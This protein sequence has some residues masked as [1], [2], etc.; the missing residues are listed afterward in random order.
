MP[1][2]AHDAFA[3]LVAVAAAAVEPLALDRPAVAGRPGQVSVWV[4]GVPGTSY[5]RCSGQDYRSRCLS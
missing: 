3:A 5:E 1:A 4:R 2:A